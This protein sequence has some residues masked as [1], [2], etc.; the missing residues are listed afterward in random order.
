MIGFL[1]YDEK[2]KS[3]VGEKAQSN[4]EV[5]LNSVPALLAIMVFFPVW[6]NR[7]KGLVPFNQTFIRIFFLFL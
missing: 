7:L 1:T 3:E 5:V 4:T 2:T 6:Y